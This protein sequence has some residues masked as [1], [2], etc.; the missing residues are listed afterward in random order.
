MTS[1]I[2]ILTVE[3]HF[4]QST[5]IIICSVM[6]PLFFPNVLLSPIHP[7]QSVEKKTELFR[8]DSIPYHTD[9]YM[10]FIYTNDCTE[11]IRSLSVYVSAD[12]GDSST[13]IPVRVRPGRP[14]GAATVESKPLFIAE[15]ISA[16][17]Y[18]SG[19]IL[20]IYVRSV[21]CAGAYE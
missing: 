10:W 14:S 15:R 11:S 9:G 12:P 1:I 21:I 8:W 5:F 13:P 16:R 4:C 18:K 2:S 20:G 19:S 17:Q 7:E 3:F 6:P